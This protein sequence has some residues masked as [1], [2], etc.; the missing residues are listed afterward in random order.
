MLYFSMILF[1]SLETFI[2]IPL[3]AI[4]AVG[5]VA[6]LTVLDNPFKRFYEYLD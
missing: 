2:G 1:I 4:A 6:A 5:L 3:A